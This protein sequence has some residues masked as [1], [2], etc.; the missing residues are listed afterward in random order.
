MTR[1]TLLWAPFGLMMLAGAWGCGGTSTGPEGANDEGIAAGGNGVSE[2]S[3]PPEQAKPAEESK[4]G[5][6]VGQTQQQ[7]LG[8]AGFGYPGMA[9]GFGYPGYGLG[10]GL[11]YGG[12]GYGYGRSYGY[13][14]SCVNGFCY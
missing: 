9:Y 5:E 6:N 4:P 2:E 10:Y 11:G 1:K 13:G 12:L 3:T 14:I 7:W 8:Y